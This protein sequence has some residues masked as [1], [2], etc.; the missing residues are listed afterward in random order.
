[1][2]PLVTCLCCTFNRPILLGESIKCFLDQDYDNKEMIILN[3]Q[4]GVNLK[5]E[6]CP[7]N[8]RI[9]NHPKRFN[10][11]GEKRNYLKSLARGDYCCIWDDDDLSTPFRISESVYFTQQ[12]PEY[13]IIK[14]KDAFVSVDNRKYK[15]ATNRFHA[16][17]VIRKS[18][19]DKTNYPLISIG[20]DNIFERT[21]N[22]KIIDMF[23]SF[24]AVLRWGIKDIYHVSQFPS[25]LEK[26]SW[27]Y[28]LELSKNQLSG[29]VIIKPEFQK[30]YW[31]DMKD[32]L[33]DINP[34][35][36]Q[37]WYKKIGKK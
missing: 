24:W 25:G 9:I 10:S 22:I 21:A 12:Y 20:E 16:Q 3:D 11:L 5:L 26:R 34:C 18:Y 30:D 6:N 37:E 23:P 15:V 28:S 1:M 14:P 4:E 31:A 29:E 13:D 17:A 19:M 36:G 33:N 32:V 35:L 8:I 7:K 27:D 2:N